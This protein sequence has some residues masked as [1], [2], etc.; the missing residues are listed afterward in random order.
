MTTPADR[1][2][3][4]AARILLVALAACTTVERLANARRRAARLRVA[5]FVTCAAWTLWALLAW[6][7][8][9]PTRSV[10]LEAQWPILGGVTLTLYGRWSYWAGLRDGYAWHLD[11]VDGREQNAPAREP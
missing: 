11:H 1:V 4:L 2:R 9:G 3:I 6:H 7:L 8:G 10:Y 5:F